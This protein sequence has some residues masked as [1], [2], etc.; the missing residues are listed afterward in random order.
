MDLLAPL[1][2]SHTANELEEAL[3]SIYSKTFL[4]LI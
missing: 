2:H 1:V 3:Q 4:E